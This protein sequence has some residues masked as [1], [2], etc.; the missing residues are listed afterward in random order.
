VTRET[1]ELLANAVTREARHIINHMRERKIDLLVSTVA[2]HC[3]YVAA[4]RV[5]TESAP[6]GMIEEVLQYLRRGDAEELGGIDRFL[7]ERND[8]KIGIA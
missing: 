2:L 7:H 4:L 5:M 8:K 3:A 1:G 6:A